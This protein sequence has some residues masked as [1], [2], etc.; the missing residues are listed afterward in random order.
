MEV[1]GWAGVA[2]GSL[3]SGGRGGGG[4]GGRPG[5]LSS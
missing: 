5:F 2:V 3:L 4:V 1:L